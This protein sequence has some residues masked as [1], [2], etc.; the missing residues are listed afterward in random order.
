MR[1]FYLAI[2]TLVLSF[3]L[4]QAE[5]LTILHIN[6]HHS[7]LLPDNNMTLT[8]AGK[9]TIVKS[10]GFP[11]VVTTFKDLAAGK[12]NILKLHAGDAITGDLYYT[13]FKGEADAALMNEVCFDAFELG[14]HEFDGGEQTLANFLD[15]IKSGCDTTILAANVVPK[16]GVS[17]LAKKSSTDYIK[18]YTII[19]KGNMEIGIVGIDIA[20]KT[21]N[22]SNP[23]PTTIFLDETAT[24]QKY[25]NELKEKGI[26]HIVL[27]T[28]HQYSSDVSMA[29]KMTGVDV[30]IGG[31]SHSLLGDFDALGLNPEGPYP[32]IVKD[33]EGNKVCIAQAW[34]YSQIVGELNIDFDKNGL[35]ANCYGT[36][37]MMLANSFKR[38]NASGDVVELTGEERE[39]VL[40]AV[41]SDPKLSIVEGDKKSENILSK[42]SSRINELQKAKIGYVA[43]DLC[44]EKIPGLGQS[45]LCDVSVTAMHGS[46][47]SSLVAYS[48]LAMFK[49]SEIAIQNAG[50]IR[51]DVK[52]GDFTI[53]DAY[54][55]LP[56]G[57]T[58]VEFSATG[59]EIKNALEDALDY[60]LTPGGSPGAYP[61]AAG[62]RWHVDVSKPK[63]E[64][65]SKFE[66][67]G[68]N[69]DTWQ[70][71]D[72]TRAYKVVSNNYIASGKDG[73]FSFASIHEAGRVNNTYKDYAEVLIDYVRKVGTLTKLSVDYLS[74][75]SFK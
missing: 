50:G 70:K 38:A 22:S 23:A 36:S 18:P 52:A 13:L 15:F 54:R 12:D 75:Q 16:V 17:P 51:E 32:T 74:T 44:F 55:V 57:N 37:H 41:E 73:Y 53:G 1:V 39:K 71:F 2:S 3:N 19:K 69:E 68:P 35:V 28:H 66:Y 10:G 63:G 56:F 29:K 61:Y 67:K 43:S 21:K 31:D 62:L 46:E 11:S 40:A 60:A 59:L 48:Y 45:K 47:I 34:Q 20:T 72:L 25:V 9:K 8:L 58:I 30:I 6:D 26:K 65:F 4:V 27:L 33:A 42:F 5:T 7:H 24:A 49:N 64:R 14:N